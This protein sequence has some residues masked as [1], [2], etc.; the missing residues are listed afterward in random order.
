MKRRRRT[1][2]RERAAARK[3]PPRPRE[4]RRGGRE[5]GGSWPLN[6]T[7]PALTVQP[8]ACC[9]INPPQV[10]DHPAECC[11]TRSIRAPPWLVDLAADGREAAERGASRL[12]RAR[13]AGYISSSLGSRRTPDS[14]PPGCSGIGDFVTAVSRPTSFSELEA[15]AGIGCL[16]SRLRRQNGRFSEV[17][18]RNLSLLGTA[19]LNSFGVRIG[20]RCCAAPSRLDST[21]WPASFAA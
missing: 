5:E 3:M 11:P 15:R 9:E 17:T 19:D 6:G 21:D 16:A 20:V 8:A 4:P 12:P 7:V 2:E 10:Q 14:W 1:T 18:K 13:A